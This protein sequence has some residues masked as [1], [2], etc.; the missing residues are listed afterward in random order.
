M[1]LSG[2]CC[3]ESRIGQAGT[4]KAMSDSS[5]KHLIGRLVGPGGTILTTLHL[6]HDS[7]LPVARF[8]AGGDDQ[9]LNQSID[10]AMEVFD[11]RIVGQDQ[12]YVL[13]AIEPILD[14]P[15]GF[16]VRA[17]LPKR[18]PRKY[19][20][21]RCFNRT[22]DAQGRHARAAAFRDRAKA[23]ALFFRSERAHGNDELV[24]RKGIRHGVSHSGVRMRNGF[25]GQIP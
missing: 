6:Y 10:P 13:R 16:L 22:D 14:L 8:G 2:G 17:T 9:R 23:T 11:G 1:N 7:T 3:A 5:A 19:T 25:F 24:R 20:L 12:I 18:Q 21:G 15:D 4:V